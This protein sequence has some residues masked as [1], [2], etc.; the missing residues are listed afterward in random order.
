MK[1]LEH[2]RCNSMNTDLPTSA[3]ICCSGVRL[4][5]LCFACIGVA[6]GKHASAL[7][8]SHTYKE[9]LGVG[10]PEIHEVF[11]KGLLAF[12]CGLVLRD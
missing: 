4:Q 8:A 5:T 6:Y 3:G 7:V 2:L 10:L 12:S 9:L 1:Q 11:S